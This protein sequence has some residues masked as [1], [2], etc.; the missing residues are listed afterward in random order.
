MAGQ[1]S[2]N[3]IEGRG[4]M[5]FS[6]FFISYLVLVYI[7]SLVFRLY[8]YIEKQETS[9]FDTADIPDSPVRVG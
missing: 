8:S 9:P 2:R 6:L 4:Y 7:D 5:G 3:V 1:K